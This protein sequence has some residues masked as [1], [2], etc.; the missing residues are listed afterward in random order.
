MRIDVDTL[1]ALCLALGNLS[2]G[3]L[4]AGRALHP[5]KHEECVQRSIEGITE[6]LIAQDRMQQM[7]RIV[8]EENGRRPSTPPTLH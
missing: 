2:D 8:T 6:A 5:I 3:L 7:L 4:K 1:T